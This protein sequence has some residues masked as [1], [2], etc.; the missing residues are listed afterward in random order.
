MDQI[1]T[2]LNAFIF[3]IQFVVLVPGLIVAVTGPR[4]L[5]DC[6]RRRV[7]WGFLCGGRLGR[8][9]EQGLTDDSPPPP[10]H[11][12]H[13]NNLARRL[14]STPKSFEGWCSFTPRTIFNSRALETRRNGTVGHTR[15]VVCAERLRL[16]CWGQCGLI[17]HL[18]TVQTTGTGPRGPRS[19]ADALGPE[20]GKQI[21]GVHGASA[22]AHS[23]ENGKRGQGVLGAPADVRSP[24][25]GKRGRRVLGAPA[26]AHNPE[27]RQRGWGVHGASAN[28]RGLERGKRGRW[29]HGTY[30][31]A[32][33]PEHGKRGRRVYGASASILC[34]PP[35]KLFA[36][37]L[38]L[39]LETRLFLTKAKAAMTRTRLL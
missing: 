27:H 25:H 30:A 37:P 15:K 33:R 5:T 29:V 24:D 9:S 39:V 18:C 6:W 32:H 34:T 22:D 1:I 20:H 28:A 19:P 7:T 12:A 26:D 16:Y 13:S 17:V 21:Q 10:L 23:P 36:V 8:G 11:W 38:E 3:R 14:S 35:L 4:A 31:D 2:E